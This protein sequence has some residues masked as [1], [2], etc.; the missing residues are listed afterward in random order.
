MNELSENKVENPEPCPAGSSEQGPGQ[1]SME[2]GNGRTSKRTRT[3][4]PLVERVTALR[5]QGIAAPKDPKSTLRRQT[6]ADIYNKGAEVPY[7]KLEAAARDLVCS[8][9]ERQDRMNEEIFYKLNDLA[10]RVGDLEEDRP[11]S[12]NATGDTP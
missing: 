2:P 11:A 6:Q 10:F 8:L 3:A 7:V 5:G 12:G 1:N 9:M 4:P